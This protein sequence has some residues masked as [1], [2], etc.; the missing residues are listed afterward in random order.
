MG[1]CEAI[2]LQIYNAV[3]QISLLSVLS[4]FPIGVKY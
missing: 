4:S 3:E 1:C 2:F